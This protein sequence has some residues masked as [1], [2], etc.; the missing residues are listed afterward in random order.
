MAPTTFDTAQR[1]A[2]NPATP[3]DPTQGGPE[4]TW[5]TAS[6]RNATHQPMAGPGAFFVSG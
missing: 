3:A 1:R 2:Y 4:H 6:F 5:P